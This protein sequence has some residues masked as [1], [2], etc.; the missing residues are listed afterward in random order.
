M[1]EIININS[2]EI[3][4]STNI[5]LNNINNES[6]NEQNKKSYQNMKNKRKNKSTQLFETLLGSQLILTENSNMLIEKP[7]TIFE[8]LDIFQSDIELDVKMEIIEKLKMIILK[9]HINSAIILE[10]SILKDSKSEIKVSFL[11]EL[12]K[13]L[14]NNSREAKLIEELLNLLEILIQN[15]GTQ[16]DYFWNIFQRISQLCE[17]NKT[18]YDGTK[19]L[20]F[21]KILNKLFTKS[22][23]DEIINPSKFFFFNNDTSEL[24][25][26]NDSLQSKNIYLLNGY[27]FGIWLYLE[28]VNTDSTN[29]NISPNSTLFYIKTKKNEIIEA[30]LEDNSIYY[31]CGANEIKSDQIEE[32]EE[33]SPNKKESESVEKP[34]EKNKLIE[35]KKIETIDDI[36]NKEKKLLGNI[37]YNQ[38]TL[39]IFSHKP[40]GFL[41][42][43]Q[44]IFYMNT[45]DNEKIIEYEYPNFGNQ[46]ISKI[47]ICKGFTGLVS[48]IFMFSQPLTQK[49]ILEEMINYRFGLY[50][51]QNINIF[52]SYVEQDEL[53]DKSNNEKNK[54]FLLFKEFFK[55]IMFIYSPCRI[56]DNNICLD[57]V[58]NI[59]AEMNI[60]RELN[61]IGGIYSRN[62]YGNNIYHIGGASIF[63]PIYEYIFSSI[64]K[65]SIIL[66]EGIQILINI[67]KNESYYIGEKVK[68]DKNFFRNLY[69]LIDKNIKYNEDNSKLFTK[70]IM[71]KFHEL[72]VILIN[73][74]KQKYFSKS[75][76]DYIFLNI[77]IIKLYPLQVQKELYQKLKELYNNNCEY[78]FSI[79]DVKD[80]LATIIELYDNNANYY[81]CKKHYQMLN[82]EQRFDLNNQRNK[83]NN[84][85]NNK[86]YGQSLLNKI[87]DL[88]EIIKFILINDKIVTIS[89]IESINLALIMEISP[90]LQISLIK[91]LQ[92]IFGINE[93]INLELNSYNTSLEKEYIKFFCDNKGIDH[94]L[95]ILATSTLDVRYECLRLLY[96]I[97][98]SDFWNKKNKQDITNEIIPFITI[99]LFTFKNNKDI[100]LDLNEFNVNDLLFAGKDEIY[101]N[102]EN[103]NKLKN[104]MDDEIKSINDIENDINNDFNIINAEDEK[105]NK[106]D[107]LNEENSINIKMIIKT[108][109]LP[110]NYIKNYSNKLNDIFVEKIYVFLIQWL[111]NNFENPI[112]LDDSDEIGYPWILTILMN[113]VTN[114]GIIIKT[115]FLRDLYTLSSYNLKNSK[116]ILDN[117]YFH[118][119]LLD[120]LL[121]YQI[122]Y[123]NGYKNKTLSQKGICETILSLGIKL[124]NIIIVNSTMYEHQNEQENNSSSINNHIYIFQFLITWLYKFKKMGNIHFSSA[125]NLINNIISDLITRLKPMLTKENIL[126][127]NLIWT[128]FLNLSLIAY[129]FYFIYNYCI[130]QNFKQSSM[131]INIVS[132]KSNLTSKVL[133]LSFAINEEVLYNIENNSSALGENGQNILLLFYQNLKTIWDVKTK[134]IIIE[135]NVNGYEKFLNNEI[136]GQSGTEFSLE[137][138]LLLY[139]TE[140]L[141]LQDIKSN[142]IMESI[143]NLII[144]FIKIKKAKEDVIFWIIELKKFL[145]YLLII[146]HNIRPQD[147]SIL[148]KDFIK[149][150]KEKISSVFI[151]SLNF[152]RNEM[153]N[154][155]EN[156]ISDN[157]PIL[158]EYT[159]LFRLL[160]ISYI[161]IIERILIEKEKNKTTNGGILRTLTSALGTLKNFVFRSIEYNYDYSPFITIYKEIFLNSKNEPLFNLVDIDNYKKNNFEEVFQKINNSQEWKEALFESQKV[162][163]IINDQFALGYYEKNTKIRISNGDNIHINKNIYIN[164]KKYIK[165]KTTEISNII[166]K[167]L[168]NIIKDINQSIFN[169]ILN[170]N[171]SKTGLIELHKKYFTWK[172]KWINIKEYIDKIN[173]GEIKFKLGN[174]YCWDFLSTCLFSIDNFENYLP[175][176]KKYDAKKNLFLEKN[177][178]IMG[179]NIPLDKS[180]INKNSKI[181]NIDNWTSFQLKRTTNKGNMYILNDK[182]ENDND[183]DSDN[184]SENICNREISNLIFK[185][186]NNDNYN[187][188][189]KLLHYNSS[190]TNYDKCIIDLT[191]LYIEK[192]KNSENKN[193]RPNKIYYN[194]C[195]IKLTGHIPGCVICSNNYIYFLMNYNYGIAQNEEEKC[196]GS[197]FCFDPNKHKLIRKIEKKNIR[198][199]FKKR[200]YYREDSLELFTHS[201]KSYYIKFN[202]KKD[203]DEFFISI[204]NSYNEIS[205]FKEDVLSITKK[206]EHWDISTLS[207]LSI[208]NNFASRSFKDLT[209]YPVFPWVIKNYESKK[210]NSFNETNIRELNKPIGALGSQQRLECFLQNY[211]ESKE[212]EKESQEKIER[213]NLK[214]K[215]E[216]EKK[217]KNTSQ[218]NENDSIIIEEKRYF[219][220]S[221][222]S[223]PFYVVHYMSKIFPYSFCAI[224]LQGDGFDK[225]E[226]QFLSMINSWNNCMNETTDIRELI[227]EFFFLPEMFINFNKI[228]FFNDKKNNLEN[229]N[230]I[231]INDFEYPTWSKNNPNLF[232]IKNRLALESDFVSDNISNWVDLIFGFKQKGE[233]AEKAKNLFFDFTYEKSIDIDK[234]QKSNPDEYNSLLSKVDIGQTPS[235]IYSRKVEQRMKRKNI[236]LKKIINFE[237]ISKWKSHS[238][239]SE[240]INSISYN[241]NIKELAKK[242]LIY[243]KALKNRRTICVFNN[244]VVLFLKEEYTLFSESGLVFI[245]EKT[246]KIPT[247]LA[248]NKIISSINPPTIIEE[249][250]DV[251]TEIDKEQPITCIL[252]GKYII[253]GGYHDSKFMI[254]ETFHVYKNKFIYIYLDDESKI[255]VIKS[256]EEEDKFL[257]IGTTNGKLFVYTINKNAEEINDILT[258]HTLLIDHSKSI[259]DIYID[260]K[261][262]ILTTIS[263]DKTCNIYTYPDLKLFR[264]IPLYELN[265]LDNVFISNMPLPSIIIYSKN[266]SMFY[267][268]TIN[269]SFILKK[270]NMFKEIYSPKISKDVYGRDYLIYGTKYKVI[271]ICRLPLFTK[272]ECIEIKNDNYNFPIKSLELRE[273]SEIIYYWRL[274]NYNLSYLKN[275]IIN[276]SATTD[277]INLYI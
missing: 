38:W 74:D 94:L 117:K 70:E 48:N 122:M 5:I 83:N 213:H 101:I 104:D 260:T 204:M 57:L 18:N 113:F 131:A 155:E 65:S 139:S 222:Y 211:N 243:I 245:N 188:I 174:H 240:K 219:Y 142:S 146:S 173:K 81:C 40:E 175:I 35:Q 179:K 178:I 96:L 233:E 30:T 143:L 195:L 147:N 44:L 206:W 168:K 84:N 229:I 218:E 87:F 156:N 200:Y 15:S 150:I 61:L 77:N 201:N 231:N 4:L 55:S 167:S 160:I 237:K 186:E 153:K 263:S 99:N 12:V 52:K 196:I 190:T 270:K 252:N 158:E 251:M 118:Q 208:I 184:N 256:D 255:S 209:Q 220:S 2:N 90:C 127:Y 214:N 203:R 8:I 88:L 6:K 93:K 71:L 226:R 269:G 152:I 248:N 134:D 34:E 197:L 170:L 33:E 198:Q 242:M 177:E 25:L 79:F 144:M 32:E 166:N 228:N 145:I 39:L 230:D 163:P 116:I 159:K 103:L 107:L 49:K 24:L 135:D 254:H 19:F 13:I 169:N 89:Q 102:N 180:K 29:K 232:I 271:V 193:K 154:L 261:L 129:E 212:L 273:E 3:D 239:Q 56:K 46:K 45:L 199:I 268:Y 192:L 246:I 267:A 272:E 20:L 26:D 183:D 109:S 161:L 238:S 47:G 235:Q 223:N 137:T 205:L 172:G 207:F 110:I 125:Y 21:L 123:D 106:D 75:F 51:E 67:F 257:Y 114:N 216:K 191:H 7:F 82:E 62:I 128:C 176:F 80:I 14:I 66:E 265:S 126:Q 274:H 165:N 210:L 50:N 148:T 181:I 234:C 132:S 10:K 133:E 264:V 92:I 72:G 225:R 95:Y 244:G 124:H 258:Y 119:W 22:N 105:D 69:Y 136:F 162:L 108:L 120:I 247:D 59:N 149:G 58:N 60:N 277:N 28:K 115:K 78:L 36:K 11:N 41:Q 185:K 151:I 9:H 76:F 250:F 276:K 215:E 86:I 1:N 100:Y 121:I 98:C 130:N 63:L 189:Q 266:D 141:P 68:E 43:P 73:N 202:S 182:I 31:Y 236:N 112:S 23:H 97:F 27:T 111:I 91:I 42:K 16:I 221:H 187:E 140:D 227:P 217:Q 157:K 53:H 17:R 164:E 138:N 241:S 194:C 37:E 262:N 85:I 259:N 224:E 249:D 64:Y 275:K 171:K 54:L 253:K